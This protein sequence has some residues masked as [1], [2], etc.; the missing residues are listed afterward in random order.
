VRAPAAG[1]LARPGRQPQPHVAGHEPL[2][3]VDERV[4]GLLQ[5]AEPEAVVDQLG[6]AGLEPALLP[7]QVTL[8]ADRLQVGVGE[9]EGEAG[10]ALVGL[11]ALDPDPPVLDHVDAAPAVRPD[12]RVEPGHHLG[13]AEAV[14]V[15]AGRHPLGEPDDHVD[16]LGGG[17]LGQQPDAGGRDRPGVLH[18]AALD[19]PAP[20]VVVDGVH[21]LLRR[22]DRDVVVVGVED[23]LLPGHAPRPHRGQHVEVGRQRPG[24][25][26]EPHLVVA[27]AGTAVGDG[28]RRVLAG[29]RHQVLDDHRP[30]QRRDQRVAPLVQRVGLEHRDAVIAGELLAG[31]DHDGVDR[32]GAQGALA[33]DV[34]VVARLA[35]V[36]RQGD[37]LDAHVVGHPPDGHRRVEAAAVGQDHSLRHDVLPSRYGGI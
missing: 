34:P 11:P 33:E 35:D 28:V 14:A 25:H 31:V 36:D 21:L 16:R 18:L 12:Q 22:G 4:D 6:V 30:G 13:D 5:R 24:R 17:R 27:L 37:H 19:G 20:Q 1:H 3:L 23:A 15:E 7:L 9:H 26:L 2:A 10:R 32:A 29:G 8:E